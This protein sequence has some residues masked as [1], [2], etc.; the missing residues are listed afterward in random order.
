MLNFNHVTSS[1]GTL[2]KRTD[3]NANATIPKGMWHQFGRLPQEEQGVFIE[4]TDIPSDW[5]EN[6]PSAS[7]IPD[8]AGTI[9]GDNRSPRIPKNISTG[10]A[11][12]KEYYNN[13]SLPVD[14]GLGAFTKPSMGSLIDVCGFSTDSKKIGTI[15]DKKTI[16]EAIVAIP[17][18]ISAGER[19]FFSL[20]TV[21]SDELVSP[22]VA[23]QLEKMQK[24][25]LPPKL[26]FVRNDVP[27]I[28]MYIFEFQHELDRNDLS[29]IWQNLPPKLGVEAQESYATVA[30]ELFTNELMGDWKSVDDIVNGT[31]ERS[32]FESEVK[33]MVFKVK[34]RAKTDYYAQIGGGGGVNVSKIAQLQKYSYN[35]PYDFCSIV[36]MVSIEPEIEFGVDEITLREQVQSK[37]ATEAE[38]WKGGDLSGAGAGTTLG[39][40]MASAGVAAQDASG[41]YGPIG[42]FASMDATPGKRAEEWSNWLRDSTSDYYYFEQKLRN[43]TTYE[44]NSVYEDYYNNWVAN[45]VLPKINNTTYGAG[46]LLGVLG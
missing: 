45:G 40:N 31:V 12:A 35:W 30:H 7:L 3:A 6:H 15:K 42:Q 24:Y 33:W 41:L 19:Q 26:D 5:L 18:T 43:T 28:A 16:S 29:H 38:A 32:G 1:D 39:G 46:Y 11:V 4:V 13:Y 10:D 2:T 21:S 8:I 20:K 25:I 34:Q 37:L 23:D 36:E 22:S 44:Y 14:S 17:F 9:S 27:R